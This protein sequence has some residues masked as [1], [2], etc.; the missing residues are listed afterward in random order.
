[1]ADSEL[2]RCGK[3][4]ED[5]LR[6][7]FNR[8]GDGLQHWC[9]ECFREYFRRRGELHRRQSGDARRMRVATARRFIA[10]Y[11]AIHHCVDCGEADTRVLDFDHVGQK[12]ALVSALAAW[13][14]PRARL[15][16]EIALCA[17]RCANCHR[18]ITA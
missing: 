13:G 1:V 16:A 17:V 14:A 2:K 7:A 5:L 11:L 18:R 12:T 9:R 8:M 15:E 6:A 3:C 10:A 4:G